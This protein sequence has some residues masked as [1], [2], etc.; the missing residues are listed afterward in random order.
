MCTNQKNEK[1]KLKNQISITAPVVLG[2]INSAYG[3]HGWLK[4]I[5]STEYAESIFHYQ[6][7]FIKRINTWQQI[8]LDDWKYHSNG[9]IIK[10]KSIK[11]R[12][13]AKLLT[14]CQI[15]VDASQLPDLSDG[16]YYWK[17]LIGCQVET[18]NGSPLGKVI[19]LIETGSNDVMVVKAN[20]KD[21][22]IIY[23][24]LIPFLY[25]KVIKNIDLATSIIQVDWDPIF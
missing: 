11:N 20:R 1:I 24:L 12:E 7:W 16:E 14:N 10:I 8:T 19:N 13:S 25:G 2:Q 18:V 3:I 6:P 23:E 22:S 21:S 15:I 4:M 9:I 5:S 17:D